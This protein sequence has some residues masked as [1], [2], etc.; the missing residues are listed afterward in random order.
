MVDRLSA[1]EPFR[2]CPTGL[3]PGDPE[4][5][6]GPGG[7]AFPSQVNASAGGASL[8][9]EKRFLHKDFIVKLRAGRKPV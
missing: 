9:G 5:R 3:P 1:T 6:A 2:D 4:S 8:L 7:G